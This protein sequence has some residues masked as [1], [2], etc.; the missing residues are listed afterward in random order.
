M[1]QQKRIRKDRKE[2]KKGLRDAALFL[3]NEPVVHGKKG[4]DGMKKCEGCGSYYSDF[5]K[6]CPHCGKADE[7]MIEAEQNTFDVPEEL[8]ENQAP[9]NMPFGEMNQ[10][11]YGRPFSPA[12]LL[13]DSPYPMKWHKFLMVIMIIGG[14]VNILI[15]LSIMLGYSFL[16]GIACVAIGVF[17]LVV[18]NRL[19]TFRKDAPNLLMIF[20]VVNI[21]LNIYSAFA[22]PTDAGET[23]IST[24]LIIELAATG[25]YAIVNWIYYNKRRDLFKY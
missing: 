11:Q 14:I 18:R 10:P 15:G 9:E 24:Q 7:H 5:D 8:S 13:K 12:D 23:G 3:Y 6:V 17:Q 25:A 21:V 4:A 16:L 20:F 1:K 22:I 19:Q 2:T